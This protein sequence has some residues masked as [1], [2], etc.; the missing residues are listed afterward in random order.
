MSTIRFGCVGCGG[1]GRLHVLNS[2]FVPGME[3]VA[4]A[5]REKDRAEKFLAEFGGK[6]A[7]ENPSRIFERPGD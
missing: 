6:Y 5:D 3:V 4:Y 2:R 7:T 1:M